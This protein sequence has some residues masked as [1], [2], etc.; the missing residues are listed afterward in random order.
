M[1]TNEQV[2]ERLEEFL[3]ESH[4]SYYELSK[5]SGVNYETIKSMMR[6]Q[7]MPTIQNL[8]MMCEAL[9]IT[10]S[11]FFAPYS[12][13]NNIDELSD[14]ELIIALVRM[15]PPD[16]RKALIAYAKFLLEGLNNS[17]Q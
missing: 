12:V 2:I 10:L 7:S 13:P 17:V 8:D 15:L 1:I 5:Q 16:N 4:T 11:D 9:N 3:S 14:E 6:R